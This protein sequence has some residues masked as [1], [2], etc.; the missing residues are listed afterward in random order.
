M[1]F[2][3][4][5]R[6]N[7]AMAL[8]C[9]AGLSACLTSSLAAQVAS[10]GGGL[11]ASRQAFLD[12]NPGT[13]FFELEGE[14]TRVYGNAF[15]TGASAVESADA[16]LRANAGMLKSN[17]N[18][19]LP[20]GP[21]G[22]GTHVLPMM[23]NPG[24][25]SYRFSLVGYTQHLNGVPVFRGDVRCL[26]RNEPGYPLV[27]VS[28]AL[29]DVREFAATFAGGAI[30]P[31]QLD[32]RKATRLPLN[33]FGP[34]AV[35]SDQE[36]VIWAGYD[37]A[38]AKEVRLAYKFIVTGTGVFDRSAHQRMLYIVDAQTNKILFQ[39]DQ[40]MNADVNVTLKGMAS[41]GTAADACAPEAAT[42]L[43]YGRAVVGATTYYADAAGSVV[44]PNAGTAAISIVS[45]VGGRW[46]NVI[47]NAGGAVSTLTQSS[48]GGALE[49]LHNPTN[50]LED[51]RAEINA[52]IQANVVRDYTLSYLP[53][54][55]T[56]GTQT[57]W[58][59]NV[60]VAGTC[61]AFYDGASINFYPAG[62]GCNNTAFSVVVHHE[63]GHHLV[64][65]AGSGQGAYGEGYGDVIGV[66]VTD[67]S[68]LAIGFQTCATGIRNAN[69]SVQ[70]VSGAGCSSAGSEVHACGTLLSGCVWSTRTNLL[71]SNP[72][73]YRQIISDLGVNSVLLHTGTT[74][75]GDITIDFLTLD[76][77]D[78]NIGNGTPHYAQI[79]GGFSA[80]G[81]PGPALQFISFAF[82]DG[83]PSLSNPSGGT[84]FRVNVTGL[85]G[86]PAAGTGTLFYRVG[87]TGAFTQTSMTQPVANQYVA[88][89][90]PATCGTILQY[91]VA[92]NATN[93][94]TTSSP[95]NA[96]TTFYSAMVANGLATPFVDTVETVLGWT[97]TTA[98]DTATTG[99]W[100]RADPIGTL[101]GTVEVQPEND[102]TTAGTNCFFTGQ[103]AAGAALGSADVDGGF[104]TL[105]SPAMNAVGGEAYLS[106]YRW[107]SNTGGASPNLDTFRVLLSND[108]GANWTALETVG[109]TGAETSGGWV[110]K[111]FL[112]EGV[113]PPTAQMK[114][115]FVADDALP[116]SVIEAAVDEVRV[117]LV[118][119]VASNPADL[120]GDGAVNAADLALLLNNWNGIGI[121]DLND[122][123]GVDAG[124][125]AILL[126]A[127]S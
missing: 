23:F 72:S 54:F 99:I 89:L 59:V 125:L 48:A 78:A 114:V 115:R 37:N 110:F 29:K 2:Q 26:V 25:E 100:T 61:N 28:N 62:N 45:S 124:D 51:Q 116:G 17:F 70:F 63:Y 19:L 76:D 50:V 69:N 56:I 81:L 46:F 118:E 3:S 42:N 66:L 108:N 10:A 39:E 8:L 97:M 27:L 35:L 82:P 84:T 40:V 68:L 103:G 94:S 5:S 101:V 38:P 102:V 4:M 117:R 93:G 74:I 80:H 47:D 20:I 67:E 86:T 21:N 106:Y 85:N 31:S 109:P 120:N 96:P 24:D 12:A 75:A 88:S 127:W 122:D 60:Q 6:R 73:D 1:L 41:Q 15:S 43:P 7:T 55:P 79:N 92:A 13:G 65:R 49:F 30:A 123:G 58:P 57:N 95:E 111:E 33:Q 77:N 36:Q 44:V 52:Y 34:G 119:C 98:G 9:A 18:D 64:N 104:T 53:T 32:L 87:S 112:I 16:F 71:A 11:G 90:P 121:G 107:Y 105:T 14:I 91:Y 83:Q 126:N 113:L 22:D